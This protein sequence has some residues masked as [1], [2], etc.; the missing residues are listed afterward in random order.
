MSEFEISFSTP[1]AIY[2]DKQS[3]IRVSCD[4]V[5][6]QRTK[7]I[8]IH[9]HYI[10]GL[11]HDQIIDLQYCPTGEQTANIFTKAFTEKTFNYLRSLLGMVEHV[12]E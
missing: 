10:R 9:M 11:V 6:R 1:T 5:Q 2:C 12:V 8:E 3:A 7:H 4:P